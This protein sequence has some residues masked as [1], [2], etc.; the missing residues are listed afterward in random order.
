MG[1]QAG[2]LQWATSTQLSTACQSLDNDSTVVFTINLVYSCYH[3]GRNMLFLVCF[4]AQSYPFASSNDRVSLL[5]LALANIIIAT[6]AFAS[7]LLFY[8]RVPSIQASPLLL[9]W[10]INDQWPQTTMFFVF[11][12]SQLEQ[13]LSLEWQ[14]YFLVSFFTDYRRTEV[15]LTR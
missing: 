10:E 11:F 3:H 8:C 1:K 5:K 12:L 2:H 9:N 15:Q 6:N 14:R 7:R 4:L 13:F